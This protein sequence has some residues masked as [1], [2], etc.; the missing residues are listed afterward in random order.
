[1]GQHH[2]A[3]AAAQEEASGDTA[4]TLDIKW[5]T[6][7]SDFLHYR[8]VND[9]RNCHAILDHG[10]YAMVERLIDTVRKNGNCIRLAQ[11]RRDPQGGDTTEAKF[12]SMV[13]LWGDVIHCNLCLGEGVTFLG[14]Y[15]EFGVAFSQIPCGRH[16]WEA[17]TL[18]FAPECIEDAIRIMV[19]TVRKCQGCGAYYGT[20]P[21][22]NVQ[23]ALYR[24]MQS[25]HA[26]YDL[27]A[28][29]YDCDKPETWT[30]GL[31]CSQ[32]V[33][34]VLKRCITSGLLRIEDPH[35]L[36]TF[37]RV[38]SHTCLPTALDLLVRE[39]WPSLKTEHFDTTR[40]FLV[41][42]EQDHSY[43]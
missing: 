33:L 10:N 26:L 19:D 15:P 28:P 20:H 22:E 2:S 17:K 39:T 25:T 35:T 1:M 4:P 30:S 43:I 16:L 5:L 41:A 36:A 31:H 42:P 3:P 38:N 37:M 11:Y 18:P 13:Q 12:L 6:R 24:S 21:V 9:G 23:H 14:E 8:I 40:L 32:L 34:L 29:D 7:A 27:G